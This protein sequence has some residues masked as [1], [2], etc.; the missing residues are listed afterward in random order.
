MDDIVRVCRDKV[1]PSHKFI[2]SYVEQLRDDTR[3]QYGLPAASR[4]DPLYP[5]AISIDVPR[6]N[7][8]GNSGSGTPI[9]NNGALGGP[10]GFPIKN[11]KDRVPNNSLNLDSGTRLQLPSS[12]RINRSG[13]VRSDE[14]D[15]EGV[16]IR[17]LLASAKGNR[18]TKELLA[19]EKGNRVTKD[20]IPTTEMPPT[21]NFSYDRD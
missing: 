21:D 9:G 5:T 19:S 7:V 10:G 14:V 11:W 15:A 18:A 20:Q 1:D 17:E 4:D 12:Q 3:R 16:P 13:F 2:R 8:N 6:P